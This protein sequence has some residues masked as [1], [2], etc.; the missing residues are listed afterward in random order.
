MRIL[1]ID[2]GFGTLGWAIIEHNLRI[3]EY[4]AIQTSKDDDIAQRLLRIH[5]DIIEII[6]RLQPDCMAVERLYFSKNTKTAMDVAKCIGVI[7][8]TTRLLGIEYS[9]YSP[10]QIK[11]ALT[12]YGRATKEQMQ[13]MVMKIFRIEELPEPDDAADAL[14]IA[15]CHS[16]NFGNNRRN[17]I[18]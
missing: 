2:P 16:F 5:V 18:H 15:A 7:M 8:L 11:H 4:G 17:V 1:G 14:A 3:I 13:K 9:E 12:G 6:E 10:S